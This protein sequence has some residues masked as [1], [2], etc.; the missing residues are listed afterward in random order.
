MTS[1][2]RDNLGQRYRDAEGDTWVDVGG[3]DLALEGDCLVIPHSDVE[4]AH[5]PL[6]MVDAHG[7]IQDVD[8]VD[9]PVSPQHYQ[10][11]PSGIECIQIT[12]HMNFNLG[13]AV[14][15]LWRAGLKGDAV[16]DLRKARWYVDREIARLGV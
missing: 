6:L 15:Y 12:E 14:K 5:G 16:D 1:N 11:H 4:S 8:V 9:D 7:H 13:N 10:A 2:N 3:G